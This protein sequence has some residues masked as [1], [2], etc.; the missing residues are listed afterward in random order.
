ME[1]ERT[2]AEGVPASASAATASVG[3]VVSLLDV[4]AQEMP[5]TMD[6]SNFAYFA[7]IPSSQDLLHLLKYAELLMHPEEVVTSSTE[8]SFHRG[9]G[10]MG[11]DLFSIKNVRGKMMGS[12]SRLWTN[13]LHSIAHY[14]IFVDC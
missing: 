2:S 3:G 13:H 4:V 7:A 6:P 5:P 8:V 9:S 12:P 10:G 1:R 14:F 11:H